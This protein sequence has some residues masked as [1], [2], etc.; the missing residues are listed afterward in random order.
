MLVFN[1]RRLT[2]VTVQDIDFKDYPDFCDAFIESASW[3]D[4]GEELTDDELEAVN[5][6]GSLRWEACYNSIT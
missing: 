5:D 4:T 2:D 6:N 3:E 1:G